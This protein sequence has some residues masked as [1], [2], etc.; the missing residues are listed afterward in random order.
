MRQTRWISLLGV[1][2]AGLL[3]VNPAWAQ[4]GRGKG[5]RRAPTEHEAPL[6]VF[7]RMTPEQRKRAMANLPP[8]RRKKLQKQLDVYDRLT[9][10]QRN[11]LDWFNHLPPNRQEAFRKV[12]KQFVQEPP[13]RQQILRDEMSRLTSMTQAERQARLSTPEV[14]S[15]FTKN[16]Q[17]ILDQM[18]EALPRD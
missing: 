11:Q 8:E 7:E 16:E 1:S 10:A 6:E 14:R 17:Q 9:P 4:R 5:G 15:R 18:S 2:L 13:E 12:Y 3:L